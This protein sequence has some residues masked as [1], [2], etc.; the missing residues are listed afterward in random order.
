[1]QSVVAAAAAITG[2]G[3][4]FWYSN[5]KRSNKPLTSPHKE[6]K[7]QFPGTSEETVAFQH[8]YAHCRMLTW[9]PKYGLTTA[10][11]LLIQRL[12]LIF[13]A[14]EAEEL[15]ACS[16]DVFRRQPE[17]IHRI[18]MQTGLR[19]DKREGNTE[20]QPIFMYELLE[21]FKCFQR[22]WSLRAKKNVDTNQQFEVWK[23]AGNCVVP[24][25]SKL[26]AAFCKPTV[27][28]HVT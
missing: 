2:A 5:N 9:P 15:A 24:L 26:M 3:L 4:L 23:N 22:T 12:L 16:P 6:E 13:E 27:F 7:A 25:R 10:D 21:V 17:R 8:L 19:R 11:R 1:M 20:D 14:F 18:A 28:P